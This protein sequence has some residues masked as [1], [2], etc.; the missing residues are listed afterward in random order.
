MEQSSHCR[1]TLT[2]SVYSW[3]VRQ[4]FNSVASHYTSDTKLNRC[5]HR[6]ILYPA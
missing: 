2:A 1:I 3:V 5:G 6:Y 4:I